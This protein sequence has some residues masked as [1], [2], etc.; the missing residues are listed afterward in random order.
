MPSIRTPWPEHLRRCS[1]GPLQLQ[2][3]LQDEGKP[4]G[5]LSLNFTVDEWLVMIVSMS[6]DVASEHDIL[7]E[8]I[9]R[10]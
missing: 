5:R 8:K 7:K 10:E 2:L 3:L 9:L 6:P 1:L 4:F